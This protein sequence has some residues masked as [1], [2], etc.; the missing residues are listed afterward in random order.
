MRKLYALTAIALLAASGAA[1][2]HGAPDDA[3][4]RTPPPRRDLPEKKVQQPAAPAP[5]TDRAFNVIGA[6]LLVGG[7]WLVYEHRAAGRETAVQLD[8]EP[9]SA[10]VRVTW[11]F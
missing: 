3:V 2:A 1:L 10:T 8:A 7:A 6:A 11:R 5:R 9:R 4:T